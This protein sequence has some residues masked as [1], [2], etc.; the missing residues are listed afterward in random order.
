MCGAD[1]GDAEDPYRDPSCWECE[2][3]RMRE[4]LEGESEPEAA[5]VCR[6]CGHEVCVGP[7]AHEASTGVAHHLRHGAIDYDQDADHVA[8]PEANV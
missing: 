5:L 1:L 8:L 4:E 7:C 3:R 2:K 6:A